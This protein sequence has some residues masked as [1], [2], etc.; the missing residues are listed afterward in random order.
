MR[1][2]RQGQTEH[3]HLLVISQ[4]L[5]SEYWARKK[6]GKYNSIWVPHISGRKPTSGA[7]ASFACISRKLGA[8]LD[9][10][11]LIY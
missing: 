11:V 3:S 2:E 9:R 8:R 5:I 4:V 6:A 10:D 7:I 1:S